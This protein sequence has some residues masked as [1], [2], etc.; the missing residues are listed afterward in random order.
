MASD[1]ILQTITITTEGADD[2]GGGAREKKG[3]RSDG[4]LNYLIREHKQ[5]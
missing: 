5:F 3:S 1:D 2:V 4:L